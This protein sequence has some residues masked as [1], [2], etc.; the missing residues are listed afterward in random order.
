ML[1]E[2]S[3]DVLGVVGVDGGE[4]PRMA[5][6]GGGVRLRH[7]VNVER[8]SRKMEECGETLKR[9]TSGPVFPGSSTCLTTSFLLITQQQSSS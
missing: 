9:A 3:S 4:D 1:M 2:Q 8:L 6:G 7:E 5:V